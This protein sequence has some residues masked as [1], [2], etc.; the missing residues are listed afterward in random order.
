[1]NEKTLVCPDCGAS[2][3]VGEFSLLKKCENCLDRDQCYR[4][5]GIQ[6]EMERTEDCDR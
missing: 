6:E 4:E 3:K 1:M 2:F 5:R